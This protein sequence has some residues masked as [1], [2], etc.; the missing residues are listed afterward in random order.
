MGDWVIDEYWLLQEYDLTTS[1]AI[2]SGHYR[3]WHSS[4]VKFRALCAAGQ[5]ARAILRI[6]EGLDQSQNLVGFRL[7]GVGTW[8]SRDENLILHLLHTSST[9]RAADPI[10]RIAPECCLHPPEN[11]RLTNLGN[12]GAQTTQIV[13]TYFRENG[14]YSQHERIDFEIACEPQLEALDALPKDPDSIGT[15]VIADF[16][17]GAITDAVIDKVAARY[18]KAEWFIRSKRKLENSWVEKLKGKIRLMLLGPEVLCEY[19]PWGGWILNSRLTRQAWELLEELRPLQADALVLITE[20]QELIALDGT[21]EWSAGAFVGEIDPIGQVG[22]VSAFY[23]ALVYELRRC[24]GGITAD[25]LS[26]AVA[27]V[28]KEG[29][30]AD[31]TATPATVAYHHIG[32]TSWE[33]ECSAWEQALRGHGVIAGGT[34]PHGIESQ[35]QRNDAGAMARI[36]VWR[37]Q[38]AL[39]GY[40]ACSKMKRHRINDVGRLLREFRHTPEPARSVGILI[41]SDPGSGKSFLARAL[42]AAFDFEYYEASIASM[43]RREEV[44]HLFGRV[45]AI[46]ATVLAAR[47]VLV[48]VDEINAEVEGPVYSLFLTPLEEGRFVKGGDAVPL[49]PCAWVFAGTDVSTRSDDKAPDFLSRMSLITR[50]DYRSMIADVP[51]RNRKAFREEA[52]LEQIYLGV[53][54]IARQYPH[55]RELDRALLGSFFACDPSGAAREIRRL[56]TQLKDVKGDRV[57]R[58]NC[59][60]WPKNRQP[61]GDEE[62]IE[63]GRG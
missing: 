54:Q 59:A 58:S 23:G 28:G 36:D 52:G 57:G 11:V 29:Q 22:W 19:K 25:K 2:G 17:K 16:C 6:Q 10:D 34:P 61:T 33:G 24:G 62:W 50:I 5:T 15:I 13:R 30:A 43:L 35:G 51:T 4:N 45:A 40:V 8:A 44:V 9:C 14:S 48:F 55:V 31:V 41:E 7:V 38:L 56:V 53:S 63:I 12:D 27:Y 3:A 49:R 18:P 39:P 37:G 47:P 21:S 60:R 32:R 46:Q 1:T 20:R 26:R 42:A